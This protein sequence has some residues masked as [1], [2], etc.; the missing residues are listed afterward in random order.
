MLET[1]MS[2]KCGIRNSK[3]LFPLHTN[4]VITP[5]PSLQ[6]CKALTS[7]VLYW[8][9]P[10][11]ARENLQNSRSAT[12]VLGTCSTKLIQIVSSCRPS[13]GIKLP[14]CVCN[15]YKMCYDPF[16]TTTFLYYPM[17][18]FII[19]QWDGSNITSQ[20]TVAN[21]RS[22]HSRTDKILLLDRATDAGIIEC[23][24]VEEVSQTWASYKQGARKYLSRYS[25]HQIYRRSEIILS[26]ANLAARSGV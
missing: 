2:C 25:L 16:V 10:P 15:G 8:K 20:R 9:I 11:L 22:I 1:V 19:E 23:T 13:I 3:S 18:C 4:D 7:G 14:S 5:P 12:S 21:G 26:A 6:A 17:Q 24:L